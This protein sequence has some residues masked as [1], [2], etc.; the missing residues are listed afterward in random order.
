MNGKTAQKLL[1][2]VQHDYDEIAES[3]DQTRQ[4]EWE[5]FEIFLPYIKDDQH[6]ADLGCGNGRF[7]EFI[8]KH[9]RIRYIGYDTSEKLLEIGK[10]KH[11]DGF[12]MKKSLLDT[13]LENE[14][15]DIVSA[16]ASLHHIPSKKLR[17]KAINEMHRILKKNGALLL[18][19]WNLFQPKY[20]KYIWKGKLRHIFTGGKYD[21][22][23]TFIPWGKS[24]IKRYYYAFKPAE[25]RKLLEENGFKILEE[26]TGN[27]I[28]FICQKS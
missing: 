14:S 10:K 16:I 19:V 15:M 4:N 5:E 8:K 1:E 28:T 21:R 27:N 17:A 9:R 22:R 20:K 3:F 6:L 11:P 13:C 24:G 12:F 25:L 7:Y 23:D 2:K 18:T 26:H